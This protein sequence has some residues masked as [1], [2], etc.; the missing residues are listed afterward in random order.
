M[1]S[2]S[3]FIGSFI[4]YAGI[5]VA[6]GFKLVGFV[7][8]HFIINQLPSRQL[9]SFISGASWG[10]FLKCLLRT[11]NWPSLSVLASPYLFLILY[12]SRCWQVNYW[13]TNYVSCWFWHRFSRYCW[14]FHSL[15]LTVLPSA[16]PPQVFNRHGGQTN[17]GEVWKRS[18]GEEQGNLVI[19]LVELIYQNIWWVVKTSLQIWLRLVRLQYFLCVEVDW[20]S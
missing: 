1:S 4:S 3:N 14:V 8:N 7:Y 11:L 15:F 10:T 17:P 20:F 18:Q 5:N 12:S 13:R 2:S 19:S 6:L 9:S 16:R